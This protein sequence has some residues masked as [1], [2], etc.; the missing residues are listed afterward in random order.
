MS[1]IADRHIL[2]GKILLRVDEAAEILGV[3]KRVIYYMCESGDLESIKIRG[4]R[5]IKTDSI[6]RLLET[7]AD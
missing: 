4:S 5:R 2:D 6:R 1:K 7:A 3:C